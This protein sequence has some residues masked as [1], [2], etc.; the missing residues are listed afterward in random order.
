FTISLALL[1]SLCLAR[2]DIMQAFLYCVVTFL[3][4]SLNFISAATLGRS[5][6]V[7]NRRSFAEVTRSPNYDEE[8]MKKC[9]A[10]CKKHDRPMDC[11]EVLENGNKRV[12]STPFGQEAE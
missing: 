10:K 4:I 7:T 6:D 8:M 9:L 5:V 11:Q 3:S 2:E 12:V 1:G